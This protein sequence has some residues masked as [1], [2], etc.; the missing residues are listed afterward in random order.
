M[1]CIS[2]TVYIP[3]CTSQGFC[4]QAFA[5]HSFPFSAVLPHCP[6]LPDRTPTSQPPLQSIFLVF[7]LQEIPAL[8]AHH[9]HFC[10]QMTVFYVPFGVGDTF[11]LLDWWLLLSITCESL[12]QSR[13]SM[14][15]CWISRWLGKKNALHRWVA[16]CYAY[17][18]HYWYLMI[19]TFI[20]S[21]A[22]IKSST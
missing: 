17:A 1:L 14:N 5:H 20:V 7:Q 18:G 9:W 10:K 3:P 11:P 6:S 12:A 15:S 19:R 22:Q 21:L 2:V 4:L 13:H 8:L 16:L